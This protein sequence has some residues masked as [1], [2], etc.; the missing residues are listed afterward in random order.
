MRAQQ[1]PAPLQMDVAFVLDR[2]GSI[3]PDNWPT[4]VGFVQALV[5]DFD[6][7]EAATR[8]VSRPRLLSQLVA[9]PSGSLGLCVRQH[10]WRL[11]HQRLRLRP[12]PRLPPAAV[13]ADTGM[14]LTSEHRPRP[15][16][17]TRASHA[18]GRTADVQ[19]RRPRLADVPRR[20]IQLGRARHARRAQGQEGLHDGRHQHLCRAGQAQRVAAP[21]ETGRQRVSWV[22]GHAVA[23][24]ADH[25]RQPGQS[26][27]YDGHGPAAARGREHGRGGGC[28]GPG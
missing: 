3:L 27:Q 26:H 25:G 22:W 8:Y 17:H 15:R 28:D 9:P 2:S 18:Q 4:I 19:Q 14:C 7:R 1:R 12:K 13:A 5:A 16:P 21:R 11:E 10:P 24:C 20:L 6:I 23:D